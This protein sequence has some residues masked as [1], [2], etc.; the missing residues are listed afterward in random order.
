MP[1][2]AA[3]A[4]PA[5]SRNERN[6]PRM[7]NDGKWNRE[8]RERHESVDFFRQDIQDAQDDENIFSCFSRLSQFHLIIL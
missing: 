7:N 6:D 2:E 1:H 8:K 4:L 3:N 5:Q